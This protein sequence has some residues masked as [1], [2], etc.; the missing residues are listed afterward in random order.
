[1]PSAFGLKRLMTIL[2][3]LCLVIGT[4]V[5][6]SCDE[7]S[8]SSSTSQNDESGG[9]DNPKGSD[10]EFGTKRS[11][12]A[13]KNAGAVRLIPSDGFMVANLNL[14]DMVKKADMEDLSRTLLYQLIEDLSEEEEV[15][16]RMMEDPLS[17]GLDLRSDVWL[18]TVPNGRYGSFLVGLGVDM[19]NEK[20]F[21]AFLEELPGRPRTLRTEDYSYLEIDKN[22]AI[23][24]WDSEKI[25][26]LGSPRGSTYDLGYRAG[27][28]MTLSKSQGLVSSSEFID[29]YQQKTD[30]SL[31]MNMDEA[32]SALGS[33]IDPEVRRQFNGSYLSAFL[34]FEKDGVHLSLDFALNDKLQSTYSKMYANDFNQDLLRYVP[35]N[36]LGVASVSINPKEVW[37]FLEDQMDGRSLPGGVR[38]SINN[39]LSQLKGSGVLALLDLKENRYN[40]DPLPVFAL[41]FDIENRELLDRILEDEPSY[42]V[43]RSKDYWEYRD[44]DDTFYIGYF[45]GSCVLT[46]DYSCIQTAI[47]GGYGKNSFAE[48]SVR[49]E[50]INSNLFA[51]VNT[52]FNDWPFAA[53]M[54]RD[55]PPN[56]Y[57]K[58]NAFIEGIQISMATDDSNTLELVIKTDSSGSSNSLNTILHFVDDIFGAAIREGIQ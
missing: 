8:E 28:L 1:M 30:A 4:S 22:E 53:E 18:F 33:D 5:F 23:L 32:F 24:C 3:A 37:A 29:F 42:K 17:S 16:N 43:R 13:L 11:K 7:S 14:G 40:S 57:N 12:R 45:K 15:L 10:R 21:E 20:D 54:K 36:S 56:V 31:W 58:L 9:G 27:E 39:L 44:G 34:N 55:L 52:N 47:Q 48:S 19:Y 25:L 35:L 46:N 26:L 51:Y 49:R 50:L 38:D 41:A 6:T 2:T